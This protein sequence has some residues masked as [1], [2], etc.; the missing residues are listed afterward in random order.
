MSF[1]ARWEQEEVMASEGSLLRWKGDTQ[2]ELTLPNSG[3]RH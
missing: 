2:V 3:H 1:K